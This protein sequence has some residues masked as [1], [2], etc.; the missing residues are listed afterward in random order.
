MGLHQ[1]RVIVITGAT[2]GIGRG[3]AI[4]LSAPGTRI[5]FT[6]RTSTPGTFFLSGTLAETAAAI[7]KRGGVAVPLACDHGDDAQVA[8]VFDR[9]A[10]DVGRV[11]LLLN[12]AMHA[13]EELILPGSFWE[14]P[15]SLQSVLDVGMRSHYVA[16][17]HAAPLMVRQRAGLIVMISSP[18]ARCYMHGPAYGAGKAAIDKMAADMAVELREHN[19]AAVSMWAGMTMTERALNSI[20]A[21][22]GQYNEY[23]KQMA[24]P[25]FYGR[26]IDALM[27][28]PGLMERSGKTWIAADLALE[29]GVRDANDQQPAS[30]GP[31]LGYP[32]QVSGAI[33][34]G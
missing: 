19:V 23:I 26:V 2:R 14:K 20:A 18:G 7:E 15:L 32:C 5:Y 24:T 34:K 17:W 12:N 3:S 27:R 22:P 33:V 21:H 28:D 11:D 31:I 9:V 16:S 25:E 13:P 1:D 4:A 10:K 6:G 29:L 30:D 8:R